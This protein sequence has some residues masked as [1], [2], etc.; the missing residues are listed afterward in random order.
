MAEWTR[1]L[2]RIVTIPAVYDAIQ[3]ALGGP[4]ARIGVARRLFADAEGKSV[5]EVGCGPGTWAP[6]LA[7]ARAYLGVDWNPAHIEL[8]KR[9]FGRE[10]TRFICGDLN[11]PATIPNDSLFDIV[12][13]IG[14]L[15]HLD[16]EIADRVMQRI[17]TLLTPTGNFIGLEPVYHP[18]QNPIAKLLKFCDSGRNIR[19]EAGYRGLMDPAF[20]QIQT[21]IV[22]DLM[23][24]PYSHCILRG[25]RG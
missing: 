24:V 18:R 25:S 13:G 11:D 5:L 12:V 8:A 15:H 9:N 22:T 19:T 7:S 14:I 2:H 10:T 23:R 17:A 3:R 1:G 4:Q 16:D 6:Y 21:E 20:G